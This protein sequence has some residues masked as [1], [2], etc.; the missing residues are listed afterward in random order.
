MS[1]KKNFA[2]GQIINPLLT[3]L[4]RSRWLDID[5]VLFC[6]FMD[7]DGVEHGQYPAVLT[8]HLVNNPYILTGQGLSSFIDLV[9]GIQDMRD[10]SGNPERSR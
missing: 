5:L 1:R 3:K 4:V 8:S 6:V 2:E 9:C 7:R 10:A